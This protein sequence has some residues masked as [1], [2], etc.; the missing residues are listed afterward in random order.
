MKSFRS[1]SSLFAASAIVLAFSSGPAHAQCATNA[2]CSDVD[3]VAC[4]LPTC[5][6]ESACVEVDNCVETCRGAGYWG[7]HSGAEKGGS[8]VGQ[9]VIDA[10]SPL[11]VCGQE[12]TSTDQVGSLNS[13]LEALCVKTRGVKERQLY[14]QL[15][16]AAL[17][18]R[19]SEGGACDQ[20][21]G[22]FVDVS[23]SDCDALCAG[24]PVEGGPTLK[25]CRDQLE[26][27]NDGGRLVD[28]K[29]A[30]GTCQTDT[31][32]LCGSDYGDC[33]PIGE[34]PQPCVRFEDS[35]ASSGICNEELDAPAQICPDKKR[36]SSP[37]ACKAARMNECTI[38]S[39]PP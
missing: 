25:E 34:D 22:R 10:D 38:D 5:N 37:Q 1:I 24:S 12:I 28:G 11:V 27:F 21:L 26:C 2:D 3:G 20:I 15:V 8:N 14:R 30:R 19:L 33:P 31:E 32:T 35:C 16:T 4:T 36:A 23:F 13:A 6:G 9:S 17:N 18:C 39:C 29:C 7:T